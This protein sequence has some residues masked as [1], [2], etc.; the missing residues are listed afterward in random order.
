MFEA[1]AAA[2]LGDDGAAIQGERVADVH[3]NE[4][5][6]AFYV[7]K[8]DAFHSPWLRNVQCT[9]RVSGHYSAP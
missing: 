4:K 3:R 6:V 9:Q 5:A 8:G 2:E 1:G 7:W